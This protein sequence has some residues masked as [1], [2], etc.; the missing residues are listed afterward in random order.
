M[1]R[2]NAGRACARTTQELHFDPV[3][4]EITA[5]PVGTER[6][7]HFAAKGLTK[8]DLMGEL[9]PFIRLPTYQ[10]ALPFT[11]EDWR[12]IQYAQLRRGTTF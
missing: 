3:S 1:Q 5:K 6:I 8:M 11:L 4:L 9:A 2:Y 12:Q 10:L 7:Q